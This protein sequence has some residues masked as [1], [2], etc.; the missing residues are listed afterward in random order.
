MSN[1]VRGLAA[2][3]VGGGNMNHALGGAMLPLVGPAV[4]D[5]G[6]WACPRGHDLGIPKGA[7]PILARSNTR[8]LGLLLDV[9]LAVKAVGF[10]GVETPTRGDNAHKNPNRTLTVNRGWDRIFYPYA[11]CGSG[12]AWS[13]DDH[14]RESGPASPRDDAEVAF[15]HVP[16]SKCLVATAPVVIAGCAGGHYCARLHARSCPS[17]RWTQPTWT[18]GNQQRPKVTLQ[19]LR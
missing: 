17:T 12:R 6:D 19:P 10:A 18:R 13:N 16:R 5:S 11:P 8:S 7:M 1:L 4:I 3:L 15:A 9:R 14:G 2:I